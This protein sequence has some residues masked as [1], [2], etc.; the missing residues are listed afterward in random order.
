VKFGN[1]DPITFEID[2]LVHKQLRGDHVFILLE[3][4]DGLLCAE[5]I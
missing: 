5:G 2:L 4:S 3:R 1:G